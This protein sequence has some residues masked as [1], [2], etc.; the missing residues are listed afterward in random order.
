MTSPSDFALEL[1]GQYSRKWQ[2]Y[3]W[4]I[5]LLTASLDSKSFN[6]YTQTT[7]LGW[8]K[9]DTKC[10]LQKINYLWS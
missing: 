10:D 6:D 9:Q 2:K 4:L 8:K 3:F 1:S 7:D 5:V